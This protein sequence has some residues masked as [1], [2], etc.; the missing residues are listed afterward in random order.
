MLQARLKYS[1]PGFSL[2]VS[3]ECRPGITVMVG[4]SGAG[5]SLTLELLAGLELPAAGRVML[6]DSILFDGETR[7][8]L[9][10][11]L[12]RCGL[13][14]PLFPHL[15]VSENLAFAAQSLPSRERARRMKETLEQFELTSAAH[16]RPAA[17]S[18]NEPVRAALARA[19]VRPP[20]LLLL[21][22][23]A[24]GLAPA[25]R[26]ELYSILRS[27]D[28]L[29]ILFTTTDLDASVEI[30]QWL[31]L[32][33]QGR[34]LQA[35]PMRQVLDHPASAEAAHLLGLHVL[36]PAEI[37]GLDP[38]RQTSR[39]RCLDTELAGPYYPGHLLGDRV[40]LC[41]L[42]SALR[43]LPRSGAPAANQRPATIVQITERTQSVVLHFEEGIS[44]EMP[45]TVFEPLRATREWLVEFPP[46]ALSI[47]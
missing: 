5:K 41:L 19:L 20:R 24:R 16:R 32:L 43:A 31:L 7:V 23:P 22:D 47:L 15:T 25:H 38:G 4:P 2:D 17:L 29:P 21:D 37:L 28:P 18:G 10:P 35:G 3:F 11:R 30:A 8:N 9:A 40:T 42:P 46:A 33:Q 39:I 12:R 1:R 36:L 27:L 13:V 14:A 26:Q 45:R 34:L 44:V 6:D